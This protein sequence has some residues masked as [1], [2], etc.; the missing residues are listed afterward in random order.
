MFVYFYVAFTTQMN[1]ED[2]QL[3]FSLRP[4]MSEAEIFQGGHGSKF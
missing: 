1:C 2:V 3:G 4:D